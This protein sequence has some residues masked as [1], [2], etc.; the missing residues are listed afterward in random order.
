MPSFNHYVGHAFPSVVRACLF[1][2]M[3]PYVRP[4]LPASQAG[5]I[6]YHLSIN[7]LLG[8]D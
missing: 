3:V 2:K 4:V 8:F 6:F 5:D 7:T 1:T